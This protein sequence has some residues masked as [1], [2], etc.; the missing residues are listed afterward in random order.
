MPMPESRVPSD[1]LTLARDIADAKPMRRGSLTE[2]YVKCN[3]AG[4]S[5][6]ESDNARHGPYYSV[7]RVVDGRTQSRWL[8]AEEAQ[9]VRQQVEQGQQFRKKVES[10]W[11]ACEHWADA[12]LETPEAA[13]PEATKKGASKRR[14]KRRFSAKS[15]SS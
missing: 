10:Y 3:K 12:E 6:S 7:S 4:C 2:R 5:C 15:R 13:S 9:I 11:Q 8:N 1:V 14:L